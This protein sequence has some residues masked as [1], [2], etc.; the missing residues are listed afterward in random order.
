MA[1]LLATLLS[2]AH[3]LDVYDKVLAVTQNNVANASTPGYAKQ[4]L[5]LQALPFYPDLGTAGGVRTGLLRSARDAYAEQAVRR[6]NTALGSQ[7]QAVAGLS[8]LEAIFDISGQTG[9]PHALN[10]FFQSASA[11]ALN[12]TDGAARQTVLETAADVA[13]AFRGTAQGLQNLVT[14]TEDELRNTVN[15]VNEL[16]NQIRAWNAEALKCSSAAD[17]AGIS[18]QLYASLETLSEL[19]GFTATRQDNGTVTI[20]LNGDTPL[21]IGDRQYALRFTLAQP[22]TPA[23]VYPDAPA[24]AIVS[25]LVDGADITADLTGGRLGALLDLRN[26]ILPSYVG[27]AAEPGDLNLLAKQFAD[28]VNGLL[29][30]G[31]ISDGPPAQAGVPL[32]TYSTNVTAA[33]RTLA[34]DA[35]LTP[36]QLAAIAPG[37]PYV[38][39]GVP[40]ALS[41]MAAPTADQDKIGGLSFA[42]FYGSLAAR[43][44]S[45]LS[46]AREG[47]Q[48]QQSLLAQARNQRQQLQGVS[49]NEE[50]M[51]LVEFQ[52]AYQANARLITVLDELTEEAIHLLE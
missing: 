4:I 1:N 5:P 18:A 34:M 51:M 20:L 19:V 50:A 25:T 8:T 21:V 31:N 15:R 38:S 47:E 43:A 26:R 16:A 41:K 32:F 33:A 42:Q 12:P 6:Q 24:T 3:A 46:A 13:R 2:S 11:W 49:L 7:Q 37:P 9:I 22:A 29:T 35:E 40:L 48:V 44:G 14:D 17:D 52:R 30:A 27:S 36:D 45:E 10:G 39:N 28:R 23:P